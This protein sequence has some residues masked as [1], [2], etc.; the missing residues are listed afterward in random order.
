MDISTNSILTLEYVESLFGSDDAIGVIFSIYDTNES[1]SFAEYDAR[2]AK[3]PRDERP[4]GMSLLPSGGSAVCCTEY[5]HHIKST[6]EP[7][8]HQVDVVGFA[9]ET[10][11]T[12]R[13]VIEEFHP[14]GHDFA[15]VNGRYL[16]DP[17]VRLV[18][19]VEEQI[20]Y[21]LEVP[22]DLVKALEIYGP[23]ELWLPL[24]AEPLEP[25]TEMGFSS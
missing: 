1:L 9:N 21:D 8:G 14:E 18:A 2:Y 13:C 24:G 22:E 11:P 15:I 25:V 3:L 19:A 10:N 6:L 20:F 4:D 17:W 16:I 12:S 5:A 23:R 7:L